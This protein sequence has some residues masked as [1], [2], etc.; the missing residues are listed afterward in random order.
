MIVIYDCKTFIVQATGY[1][2]YPKRNPDE[3]SIRPQAEFLVR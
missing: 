2:T 3:S 1:G